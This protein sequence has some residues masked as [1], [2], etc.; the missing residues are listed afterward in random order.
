MIYMTDR[1]TTDKIIDKKFESIITKE[2][3]KEYVV[4]LNL[5]GLDD[6]FY[7]NFS[8]KYQIEKELLK[9]NTLVIFKNGKIKEIYHD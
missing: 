6:E 1:E 7:N 9:S 2:N 8:N 3:K 4:F 5:N